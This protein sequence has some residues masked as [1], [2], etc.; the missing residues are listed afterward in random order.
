MG[1][2]TNTAEQLLIHAIEV[3]Q[4]HSLA[5]CGIDTTPRDVL[6]DW[7]RSKVSC[8]RCLELTDD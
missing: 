1:R 7:D 2:L 4:Q 6:S 5:A 8:H 3:D